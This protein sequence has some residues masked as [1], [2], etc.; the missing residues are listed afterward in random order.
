MSLPAPR[1]T[2]LA[3]VAEQGVRGPLTQ[4]VLLLLWI[5]LILGLQV[6]K[7]RLTPGD[8]WVWGLACGLP[9]VLLLRGCIRMVRAR[10][11]R[12][13]AL[14]REGQPGLRAVLWFAPG[15]LV[16][17]HRLGLQREGGE[18][19]KVDVYAEGFEAGQTLRVLEDPKQRSLLALAHQ[20]HLH[21]VDPV[22]LDV[23]RLARLLIA[24]T[25]LALGWPAIVWWILQR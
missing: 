15:R 22:S 6:A 9:I 12:L 8:R 4:C 5:A 1:Q 24:G 14:L 25:I 3:P 23:W 13:E 2:R 21:L 18:T 11:R 17:P 10:R 7:A 19:E 16:A 20:G